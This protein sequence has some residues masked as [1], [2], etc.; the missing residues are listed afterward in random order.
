[1]ALVVDRWP[2][3]VFPD[4]DAL[5][6]HVTVVE[7]ARCGR[8]AT[9]R[10]GSAVQPAAGAGGEARARP[11]VDDP[12]GF[13][14]TQHR[15]R[16]PRDVE[17]SERVGIEYRACFGVGDLFDGTERPVAGVVD[18]DVNPAKV[19]GILSILSQAAA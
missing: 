15:Q 10:L 8:A 5:G 4:L 3:L 2:A 13:L 17:E 14:R 18:Q 11:N 9:G 12:S 7:P 19:E 16:G 1:M 6:I